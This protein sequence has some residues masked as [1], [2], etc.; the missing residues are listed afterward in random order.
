MKL[1]IKKLVGVAFAGIALSIAVSLTHATRTATASFDGNAAV[2][3]KDKCASC[4][5]EDGM[6]NTPPGKQLKVRNLRS[7]EVQKQSDAQLAAVIAKGKDKMP[8]FE[9]SLNKEQIN[10]LVA[11][12]RQ[13]GKK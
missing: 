9:K 2:L 13:F 10:Q 6:G 5:G 4:H 8:P 7:A 11:H 3:F 12:I 1:L